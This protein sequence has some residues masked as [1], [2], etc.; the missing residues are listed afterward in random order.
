M[1]SAPQGDACQGR[2]VPGVCPVVAGR[3]LRGGGGTPQ[4]RGP[5]SP[6]PQTGLL[7]GDTGE[8]PAG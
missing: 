3:S 6:W 4:E 2:G 5:Y 1:R 8:M 7:M